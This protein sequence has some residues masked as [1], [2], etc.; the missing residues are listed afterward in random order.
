M[1][2]D[3][4]PGQSP[5]PAREGIGDE[6]I[7]THAGR[8]P[9]RQRGAVNPPV[10]RASTIVFET[11]EAYDRRK[12]S[13]YD[14]ISYGLYGT[15]TT[16]AL[17]E[18]VARIEGGTRTV[19]T[20]SGTAAIALALTAF[21]KSGDHVLIADNAYQNTRTFCDTTLAGFGIETTYYDPLVGAD[22]ESLVKPNTRVIYMESPGSLTFE[23]M[24]VPAIAT[25]ARKR[26]I[27]T[28]IDNA[29]ASPLYCK[30]L[31]LGVDIS[32]QPATKYLS[33]HSDVLLGA[34]TTRDEALFRRVKDIAGR[35]GSN[36]APDDCF[37]VLRGMRS[38]AVRMERHRANGLALAAWLADRPEV[39]R[40]LHP[41]LPGHLGHEIWKRDFKGASGLFG[42]LLRPTSKETVARM[43]ES[44]RLFG[45][46]SSWGGFESLIVPGYPAR[47]RTATPWTETGPLLRI[48]AGLESVD[49]LVDDLTHGFAVLGAG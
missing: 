6:T 39:D 24:D 22:I 12:E 35:F 20:G 19:L 17:A 25:V 40:V 38:L 32:I 11:V 4:L 2:N 13:F 14:G 34:V 36:A 8:D 1:P 15:P 23:V 37:L 21:L 18:A 3:V 45:I 44:L 9:R 33:G 48:H 31:A 28:L 7:L 26:G 10:Y 41:A 29:W 43:I 5:S 16:F 27:I 46:G 30:P 47:T 42:V 49:D